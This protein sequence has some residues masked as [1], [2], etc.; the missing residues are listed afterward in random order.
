M[1]NRVEKCYVHKAEQFHQV[2][3][4]DEKENKIK[5][6]PRGKI[7]QLGFS[8]LIDFSWAEKN[9][10]RKLPR[11][12]KFVVVYIYCD[13]F[14]ETYQLHLAQTFFR[15]KLGIRVNYAN[16]NVY[17]KALSTSLTMPS[18]PSFSQEAFTKLFRWS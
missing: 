7:N 17:L 14:W 6:K 8:F 3:R 1:M 15:I 5:E 12:A 18:E 9:S 13:F 4:L 11:Y 10:K 16:I 2:S